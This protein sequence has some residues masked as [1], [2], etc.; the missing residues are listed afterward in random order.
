VCAA[1]DECEE[2]GVCDAATGACSFSPQPD[3]TPCAGGECQAGLCTPIV[4][5]GTGGADGGGS[6]GASPDGGPSGTGGTTLVDGASSDAGSV[7]AGTTGAGGGAS[8][9]AVSPMP[10]DADGDAG[11]APPDN[12]SRDDS[13]CGC[14]LARALDTSAPLNPWLLLTASVLVLLGRSR[15]R[16]R[17]AVSPFERR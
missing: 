13:G 2:P 11:E 7:T 1:P 16:R 4:G 15:R 12:A 9:G 17:A 5:V 6:D 3:Q 10:G 14:R 8:D